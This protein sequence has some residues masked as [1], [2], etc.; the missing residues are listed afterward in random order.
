MES[1]GKGFVANE[2]GK[3]LDGGGRTKKTALKDSARAAAD[4]GAPARPA[5]P[6]STANTVKNALRKLF[7]K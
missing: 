2:L 5:A 1:A 7:G 3:L 4:S 6:D